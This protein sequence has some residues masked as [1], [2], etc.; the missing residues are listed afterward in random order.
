[1]LP[2]PA[3]LNIQQEV[4]RLTTKWKRLSAELQEVR[5]RLAN[6]QFLAKAS[7]EIVQREQEQAQL[8]DKDVQKLQSRLEDLKKLMN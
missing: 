8:L 7:P 4:N 2:L 1:H 3:D 5:S 6:P